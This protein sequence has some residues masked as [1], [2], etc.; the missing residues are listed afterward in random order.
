MLLP[1]A[2]IGVDGVE[3]VEV[4]GAKRPQLDELAEQV[5]L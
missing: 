5:R 3:L 2:R 4:V 1:D